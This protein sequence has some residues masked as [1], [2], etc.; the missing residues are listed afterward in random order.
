MT[1]EKKEKK[2]KVHSLKIIKV[3]SY[4]GYD[5]LIQTIVKA[6]VFQ[7]VIFKDGKFY[8]AH[9]VINPA[10]GQKYHDDESTIKCGM[11]MLDT[12]FFIVDALVQTEPKNN[13]K[14]PN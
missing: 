11:L 10:K 5:I 4:K 7:C 12:A 9:N 13:V 2:E 1:K 8:Q 6:N 14:Q 3:T